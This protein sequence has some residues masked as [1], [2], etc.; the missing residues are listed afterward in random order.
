M[1]ES[2]KRRL[3]DSD[4]QSDEAQSASDHPKRQRLSDENATQEVSNHIEQE[5][6]RRGEKL[7]ERNGSEVQ[8]ANGVEHDDENESED[9][10]ALVRGHRNV[11]LR[12]DCPYLDTVNRQVRV[13]SLICLRTSL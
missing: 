10:Q 8:E 6:L 5:E 13:S 3:T 9:Q 11:E 7:E 12:R 4:G 2:R 1:E